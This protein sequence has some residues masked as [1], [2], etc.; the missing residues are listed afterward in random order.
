[1][2]KNDTPPGLQQILH[3][4]LQHLFRE[5]EIDDV[6][7]REER[8]FLELLPLLHR[9]GRLGDLVGSIVITG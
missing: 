2:V 8:R 1:M 4:V 6:L 7:L 5:P 9:K 3:L